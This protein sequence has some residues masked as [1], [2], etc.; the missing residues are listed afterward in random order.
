MATGKPSKARSAGRTERAE[1]F[2]M[3][4]T[5]RTGWH[6]FVGI[7]GCGMSGL[8][9]VLAQRGH[10]VSGS[11]MQDSPVVADLIRRGIDVTIGHDRCCL[12]R[13]VDC[14]V[15]SAAIK[16][17]N[18][19]L[20]QAAKYGIRVCKYA[21]LLGE[22]SRQMKTTA[23]AG[24]HGKSTTSGW[25]AY[26][27]KGAQVD[28]SFVVGAEVEQ[29]GA[30]S[31]AGSDEQLVVEACEYDRSFLN[32]SPAAAAILNIEAD[33]LDYYRSLDEI[34]EAFADFAARIKPGGLLVSNARDDNC[35]KVMSSFRA[36]CETFAVSGEADWRAEG[37]LFEGGHGV[38]NLACRGRRL[39][40]V[41]LSLPGN[42]NVANALAVAALAREVGVSDDKICEG[43]AGFR[44]VRRRLSCKGTAGGVVVLDDYAHHPTE[45]RATLDAIAQKY[46]PR[47]L[48]C[49]FQPHQ[50]SRTR[51][52]L[53]EF[54]LSF[55]VA[56][57]VLLGD[58]YFVRDSEQERR[59]INAEVLAEQIN[60][61]GSEARCLGDFESILGCLCRQTQ[62][63]DLVVTMGA[64]DI[65]KLGDE[66]IRRVAGDCQA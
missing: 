49:V 8:A 2:R 17:D 61:N 51:F 25:L 9:Q 38:F 52:L 47:R 30:G 3:T 44:G 14:V 50:H 16:Q 64:G 12:D 7:G 4:P 53:S 23:V 65:W 35:A 62:P 41:K 58:I 19:E 54:A 29:L 26:L 60:R 45:I 6:H 28:A 46:R 32:L 37:L 22:L 66:F 15:A 27:L 40:R 1:Q 13:R 11:D 10:R 63:G 43:L 24:T 48:W 31:G 39:G 20:R 42:H 21:E 18:C 57:V 33:H 36:R 59:E 5:C 55:D 56:D 34:V